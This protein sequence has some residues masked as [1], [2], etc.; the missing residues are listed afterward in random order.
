MGLC[1]LHTQGFFGSIFSGPSWGISCKLHL[2]GELRCSHSEELLILG[3]KGSALYIGL[4]IKH[5]PVKA[6]VI[7]SH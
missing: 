6:V 1:L 2:R 4:I 3:T 7:L 5:A